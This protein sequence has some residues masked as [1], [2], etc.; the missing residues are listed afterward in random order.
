MYTFAGANFNYYIYTC[1]CNV[2]KFYYPMDR[3]RLA[4]LFAVG[5]GSKVSAEQV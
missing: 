5:Y 3:T 1:T 4:D 2:I